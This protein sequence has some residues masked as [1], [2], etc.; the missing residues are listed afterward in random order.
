MRAICNSRLY[1]FMLIKLRVVVL[2]PLNFVPVVGILVSAWLK[3][4]GTARYLHRPVWS[5]TSALRLPPAPLTEAPQYFAAKKM[6]PQQI[7][8]FVEERKWEYRGTCLP[9]S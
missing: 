7:A 2:A 9:T 8:V 3:A 6:T 4:L 5:S 1:W